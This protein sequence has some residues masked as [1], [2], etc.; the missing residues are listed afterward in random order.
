MKNPD[1]LLRCPA[2]AAAEGFLLKRRT[3]CSTI[4]RPLGKKTQ[5]WEVDA[6]RIM[7]VY[8]F[9]VLRAAANDAIIARKEKDHR[10][11]ANKVNAFFECA[12]AFSF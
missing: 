1:I 4:R 11:L 6:S 5:A 8:P 9:N 10:G 3:H 7:V 2:P 12:V